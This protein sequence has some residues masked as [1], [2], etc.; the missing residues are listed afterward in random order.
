[1]RLRE[2]G[3]AHATEI[4]QRVR[5]ARLRLVEVPVTVCYTEYSMGKGQPISNSI[6]V[7]FDLIL[8]RLF[9]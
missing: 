8:S 5:D 2:N 4:L 6:N 3:F 7:L 1:V 9:K